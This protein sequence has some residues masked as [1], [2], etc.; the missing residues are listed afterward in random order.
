[1]HKISICSCNK[2]R[3]LINAILYTTNDECDSCGFIH[4]HGN[5][6]RGFGGHLS[7]RK[8]TFFNSEF[9]Y[10]DMQT[11]SKEIKVNSF[12]PLK[13]E[14]ILVKLNFNPTKQLII[15]FKYKDN[16]IEVTFSNPDVCAVF[17]TIKSQS[18][19]VGN[20]HSFVFYFD[21]FE[22][23]TDDI[24]FTT[25]KPNMKRAHSADEKTFCHVN[26]YDEGVTYAKTAPD[27]YNS[28]KSVKVIQPPSADQAISAKFIS[29]IRIISPVQDVILN[30]TETICIKK[31]F[32]EGDMLRNL[33]NI[34]NVD[35]KEYEDF[36]SLKVTLCPF[37]V[38]Y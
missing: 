21:R 33:D 7:C 19:N 28:T 11:Y 9:I 5:E 13:C 18:I 6:E 24:L 4:T 14:S 20:G 23:N 10:E 2:N 26:Y 15:P 35:V 16:S 29:F 36:V 22:T 32:F 38:Q 31:D 12:A 8:N 25:Q 27:L 30:G 37:H 17:R 34:Y 3:A 1:M